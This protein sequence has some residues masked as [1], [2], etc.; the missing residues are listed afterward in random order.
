[1]S[2][3]HT[4]CTANHWHPTHYQRTKQQY[5]NEHVTYIL[6]SQPLVPTTVVSTPKQ[7]YG[8]EHVTYSLHS[9][10]LA[11]HHPLS[12]HQ[13]SNMEMNMS[14]TYCT[15][16]HWHTIGTPPSAVS[17]PKQQYGNEHVTYLLHSQPLAPHHLLSVHQNSNT[18]MSMS[19]TN[20]TVNHW[21]PTTRCQYTKTAILK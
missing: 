14:H 15:A 1:M 16:N 13:N 17:T 9:H 21:H 2:M 4:N 3:S 5:R 8:N 12:A 7:Q 11:S 19:H 18:Y 20:C 6:H 10:P